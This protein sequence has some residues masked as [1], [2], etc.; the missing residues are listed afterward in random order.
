MGFCVSWMLLQ[1][2]SVFIQ[3]VHLANK[4]TLNLFTF[5][6][7]LEGGGV[8]EWCR[9]LVLKSVGPWLKSFTLLLSGFVSR[10]SNIL[11][12]CTFSCTFHNLRV[13]YELTRSPD[14]S[15]KRYHFTVC[16]QSYQAT[17]KTLYSSDWLRSFKITFK[18]EPG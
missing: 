9:A 18:D 10:S 6:S 5:S 15:Y 4:E 13:Y 2:F 3:S 1:V 16:F 7:Q 11:T 17:V 14:V 8:A 12:F